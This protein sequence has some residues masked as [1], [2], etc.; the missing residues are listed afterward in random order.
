[1]IFYAADYEYKCADGLSSNGYILDEERFALVVTNSYGQ[2]NVP[3]PP[4]AKISFRVESNCNKQFLIID[5]SFYSWLG[6]FIQQH[7]ISSTS[8]YAVKQWYDSAGVLE[9]ELLDV[10]VQEYGVQ[11]YSI[12]YNNCP[13][14]LSGSTRH[15]PW[16]IVAVVNQSYGNSDRVVIGVNKMKANGGFAF[17]NIG[18]IEKVT[19][20][21]ITTNGSTIYDTSY[22]TKKYYKCYET[23]VQSWP[24]AIVDE[25][26]TNR[27]YVVGDEIIAV[28]E[29]AD[30]SAYLY[31]VTNEQ[32]EVIGTIEKQTNAFSFSELG[33]LVQ[34]VEKYFL[35]TATIIGGVEG[36]YSQ[37]VELEIVEGNTLYAI[38][39]G[40]W[41]EPIWSRKSNGMSTDI[42]P[43]L[44]DIVI[45]DGFTVTVSDNQMC[46]KIIINNEMNRSE[47]RVERGKLSVSEEIILQKQTTEHDGGLF[48]KDAGALE[49]LLSVL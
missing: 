28:S 32:G 10:K 23:I 48:V 29:V 47:L 4:T 25:A 14:S 18:H 35:S 20:V 33:S 49:V 7:G 37:E 26:I 42:I 27:G 44:N 13:S 1:M 17:R 12:L 30:A 8:P 22:S 46:K 38:T 19:L 3:S 16:S 36:P 9:K 5:R 24:M 6:S 31:K 39:S 34:T 11:N 43:G 40:N 21:Q 15:D 45:I 41:V 2:M